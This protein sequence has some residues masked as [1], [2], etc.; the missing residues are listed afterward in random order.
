MDSSKPE[1]CWRH[2]KAVGAWGAGAAV[3][4]AGGGADTPGV[5]AGDSGITAFTALH[6]LMAAHWIWERFP[7]SVA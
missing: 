1:E 4:R 6:Q 7:A 3:P 2:G 5:I